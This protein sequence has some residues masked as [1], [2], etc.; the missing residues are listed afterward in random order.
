MATGILHSFT[1][2]FPHLSFESSANDYI[3]AALSHPY[4]KLR[5]V[6]SEHIERRRLLKH[7]SPLIRTSGTSVEL[8][9]YHSQC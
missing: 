9:W 4:F 8:R 2:R 5:W 7:H 3:F 1:R 6:L